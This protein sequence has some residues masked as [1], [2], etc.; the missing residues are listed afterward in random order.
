MAKTRDSY[1]VTGRTVEEL[2]RELNFLLQRMADR[3][4]KI[5][6]I[7]GT[8][9]MEAALDMNSNKITELAPGTDDTDALNAEQAD[10]TGSS[11]TFSSVTVTNEATVGTTLS[12]GTDLTVGGD[13]RVYDDDDTLIHSME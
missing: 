13:I 11:P 2:Q 8:P 5:E 7:R 6:G 10:L 9:S 3:M 12:V 4:D 1:R